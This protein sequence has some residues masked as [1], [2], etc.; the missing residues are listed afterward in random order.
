MRIGNNRNI[1]YFLAENERLIEMGLIIYSQTN[2]LWVIEVKGNCDFREKKI[3]ENI[4]TSVLKELKKIGFAK[5]IKY[6]YYE[7]KKNVHNGV[8]TVP[9]SKLDNINFDG[10]TH[11]IINSCTDDNYD[12]DIDKVVDTM[13]KMVA[14]TKNEIK[15]LSEINNK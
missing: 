7:Y 1:Q 4:R 2:D 10:L 6:G 8:K 13:K 14:K 12:I 15:I 11:F 9:Y 5:H 3:W